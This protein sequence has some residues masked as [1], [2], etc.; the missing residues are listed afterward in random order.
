M[1]L[2]HTQSFY[3]IICKIAINIVISSNNIC[4]RNKYDITVKIGAALT[5][6]AVF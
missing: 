3:F 6:C 5:G 2:G 1:N 4:N